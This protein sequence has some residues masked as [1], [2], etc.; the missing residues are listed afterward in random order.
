MSSW[1]ALAVG[2]TLTVFPLA[3]AC[4][5]GAQQGDEDAGVLYDA[6]DGEQDGGWREE[7]FQYE[8]EDPDSHACEPPPLP[9][10]SAE[11]L[12]GAA[13]APLEL[14]GPEDS[15]DF[16]QAFVRLRQA[17]FNAFFPW[18]ATS[19]VDGSAVITGHFDYFL[20]PSLNG[21]VR[22]CSVVNPYA[23]AGGIVGIIFPA[24]LLSD[25]EGNAA[26]DPAV[27]EARYRAFL[28][29]CWGGNDGVVAA[30]ES[31]DEMAM[32]YAVNSFLGLPGPRLENAP[33]AAELLHRLGSAPVLM[34]EG[35]LPAAI[36]AEQALTE[37]QKAGIVANFWDAVA[38]EV[39]GLDIFG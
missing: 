2:V 12:L 27:Y 21:G 20:P 6:A 35:P 19:E 5:V 31:F 10:V 26:L 9:P 11:V 16:Q 17:G 15:P 36:E 34:V 30:Y 29:E 8:H 25:A 28:N 38:A 39:V 4:S 23:A 13:G 22:N 33:A 7:R 14:F 24:F 37:E 18:F 1:R 32:Q 3:G